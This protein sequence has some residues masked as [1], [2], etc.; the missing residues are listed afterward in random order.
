MARHTP[1]P[2]RPRVQLLSASLGLMA[3][4]MSVLM[5]GLMVPAAH[6]QSYP[7]K[8]IR[9]IVVAPPG[10]SLDVI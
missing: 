3:G 4:L 8:P 1:A 9:W 6:A 5:S 2:R 10:S 7:T